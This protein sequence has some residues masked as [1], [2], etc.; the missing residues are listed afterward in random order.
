MGI[1]VHASFLPHSDP[2][3]SLAF[4]RDTLGFE[5]RGD[6]GKGSDALD[7]G[8]AAEP[9]RHVHLMRDGTWLVSVTTTLGATTQATL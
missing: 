2:D 3:A 4:S 7:H 8:W 9:A 6:V 5:V 1:T